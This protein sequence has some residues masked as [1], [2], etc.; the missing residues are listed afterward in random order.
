MSIRKK[1]S[2]RPV[3]ASARLEGKEVSSER[4]GF[5]IVG[6]GASAGGLEAFMSLFKHLPADTGMGFVVVQHLDPH[7]KNQLTE[8]LAR[9]TRMPV[10]VALNKMK[11]EPNRVYVIPFNKRMTIARGRLK[12]VRR[13]DN[14]MLINEFFS[15][16][17]KDQGKWAIGVILSGTG[18]DGTLGLE[19]IKSASGITFA[20]DEASAQFSG[21]PVSA[22]ATGLVDFTLPPDR[23]ALELTRFA[24]RGPVVEEEEITDG[25]KSILRLLRERT[26]VDFSHYKT[27]TVKRRIMRRMILKGLSSEKGYLQFLTRHPEEAEAL[28]HDI[29]INVTRFFRDAKTFEFLQAKLFPQIVRGKAS[30]API[31]VWVPGCS[32]GEEVYSIAILLIEF[33]ERHKLR[34]KLHIYGTDIS[35]RTIAMAREGRYAKSIE[36]EVSAAHLRTYFTRRDGGYQITKVVRERCIFARHDVTTDPPFP[37][38]DLISCRNL[39]IYFDQ[40]LQKR[41]VPILHYSLCVG[42]FLLLGPSEGIGSFSNLFSIFDRRH[43]IFMKKMVH[44]KPRFTFPPTEWTSVFNANEGQATDV[45]PSGATGVRKYGDSILLKRL[46]L[47]GV[48]ID[49]EMRVLQF[50]GRTGLFLEHETGEATLDLL[51]MVHPD[52]LVGVRQAVKEAVETK[53]IS[54]RE[55]MRFDDGGHGHKVMIEVIPF[56]AP[57][58]REFFFHVLFKT[59]E[60]S[61]QRVKEEPPTPG[62]LIEAEPADRE[63]EF[64]EKREALEA[65]IEDK[66]A[67]NEALL[68][69]NEEVQTAN[70]EIQAVNEE[71]QSSNEELETAKEELQSSNEELNNQNVELTRLNN[72]FTNLF[73]GIDIPILMLDRGL[74]LRHFSPQAQALFGLKRNDP[75]RHLHWLNLG[76][77][78]VGKLAAQV[79]QSQVRLEKEIERG[80]GHHYSLRIQPYLTMENGP[81]GVVLFLINTDR[82]KRA[83]EVMQQLN[84][85]LE[86]RARQ[87]EAVA[88]LSRQ[89]LEGRNLK[90]L[91][92]DVVLLV[93][94]LLGVKHV[95]VLEAIPKKK[96]TFILRYGTGWKDGYVG[97]AEHPAERNTPEGLALLSLEPVVVE[98]SRTDPRF[99]VSRLHREHEIRSGISVVI[100]GQPQ[101]FGILAAC[102]IKP[103]RF[104]DE[105]VNFLQALANIVATSIEHRKLEGDLLTVS[106]TEQR[107]IGHDLHDGLG[108][109]LAGI[110]F[111]AELAAQKM[112]PKLEIKREMKLITRAIHEAILQTRM[113][114][115]GL[116]PVDVESSGLMAALKELAENTERLFRIS[117]WFECPQSILIHDNTV[118]TQLYRIAQEAIQNAVKHGRAT[119]VKISLTRSGMTTT[120]TI[121][122]NGL[123][124]STG[125]PIHHGMGLRIMHY[126][127]R[128]IGGKLTVKPAPKKGTKVVCTFK[129]SL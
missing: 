98:D 16:L 59:R 87:Q 67:A 18:T 122:D 35:E 52:L 40:E 115:R 129:E 65:L 69:A 48:L 41:V 49:S 20:E 94:Q 100:P 117:C 1:A 12:L 84:R 102:S 107:R 90:M 78:G 8:I 47:C 77:P 34:H 93:P 33:L 73:H 11:V 50:R 3:S 57:P 108:Q 116:S 27:T 86:I 123:G 22:T 13:G 105:D 26:K 19:A 37:R 70:E 63:R 9:A 91:L 53:A 42:G 28:L 83:E 99:R 121:L 66:E 79:L 55:S 68:T 119:R 126:R 75:G 85:T 101:P 113:L 23:I 36:S 110:K 21:M 111:V 82:I 44:L 7:R 95:Q 30:D 104:S 25:F 76:I 56:R 124:I 15:A 31:R 38:I 103:T 89:A 54:K 39:L 96:K 14:R 17:A 4:A 127:A 88:K 112:P 62:A 80:N 32:T 29:L 6:I 120:L 74:R 97:H 72:D 46:G 92:E 125:M 51:K 114:A 5:P 58:G 61:V 24:H 71:L 2:R 106:S 10:C 81:N 128:T 45:T 43:K 118:A 109:Q 64:T 60:P